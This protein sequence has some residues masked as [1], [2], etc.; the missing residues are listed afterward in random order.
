MRP[1]KKYTTACRPLRAFTLIELLVVIAIIALLLS[2]L[3]PSLRKAKQQAQ[4]VICKSNLHQWNMVFKMYTDDHND[5][6]HSGWG[7]SAALSQ[8][9]MDSARQYYGD[10]DK[11]RCCPTATR[12]QWNLDG[13]RGP[14]YDRRPFMA[15]GI[16]DGGFLRRGDYG[17][18]GIN[19][20]ILNRTAAA[21]GGGSAAL[22]WRKSTVE[23]AS[24]IPLLTDAQWIDAWPQPDHGPPGSEDLPWRPPSHFSRICQNRHNERQNVL[25][26]DGSVE[27]VGLKQLWT[28]KWHRNYNRAGRYTQA[29]GVTPADWYLWM[30]YFKDY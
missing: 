2:V 10:V 4:T 11:I 6:F 5:K 22:Y 19:G 20:W 26:L 23:G 18:Y 30:R 1:G 25:Y 8:W 9:W 27:T 24:Q 7:G 13:S 17:S 16:D 28:L 15:W 12:P 3:L 14:G 21:A 29:G